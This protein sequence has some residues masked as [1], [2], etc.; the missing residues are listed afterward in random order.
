MARRQLKE[1]C[2]SRVAL[3]KHVGTAALGRPAEQSSAVLSAAVC[4][5]ANKKQINLGWLVVAQFELALK[6]HGF[7]RAVSILFLIAAL[8]AEGGTDPCGDGPPARPPQAA[9]KVGVA[10]DFGGRC[11]S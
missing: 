3:G 10:F 4:H 5:K 9:E 8:A 6:G 11:C 7:S 2:K 1:S